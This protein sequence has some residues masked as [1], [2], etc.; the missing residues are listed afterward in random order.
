M[1]SRYLAYL[2]LAL[3]LTLGAYFRLNDLGNG[4]F[5]ADECI[6]AMHAE[7]D[8]LSD[9]IDRVSQDV[10]PPGLH[11]MTRPI[12]KTWGRSQ[13]ALRFPSAVFGI[14]AILF[15]YILARTQ[16]GRGFSLLAALLLSVCPIAIEESRQL[17]PYSLLC[18]FGALTTL[19]V[20]RLAL[21]PSIPRLLVAIFLC[22]ATLYT[23]YVG[24]I[25]LIALFASSIWVFRHTP[26]TR[27][28]L[29]LSSL[30]TALLFAPWG[31]VL[32]GQLGFR[33]THLW[34]FGLSSLKSMMLENGPF[35]S[36]A[37]PDSTAVA[38]TVL[39][40]TLI[41]GILV[42]IAGR[43]RG[44]AQSGA[45]LAHCFLAFVV[46]SYALGF[47][48]HFFQPKSGLLIYP[49]LLVLCA[50][51]LQHIYRMLRR[52]RV[53]QIVAASVVAPLV[54][55]TAINALEYTP[56]I[57]DRS[58]DMALYFR[59][60]VRDEP[61]ILDCDPGY[62]ASFE[63]YLPLAFPDYPSDRIFLITNEAEL[64][65]NFEK[66]IKFDRF[67]IVHVAFTHRTALPLAAKHLELVRGFCHGMLCATLYEWPDS[68]DRNAEE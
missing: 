59:D 38:G 18:L 40:V 5:W 12:I 8:S 45:C 66:I 42:S 1:R 65:E 44:E 34:P 11:L 58:R 63:F 19:S 49:I 54:V 33:P 23:H 55:A 9:L 64:R 25:L 17:R 4:S 47:W 43:N 31:P 15:T 48:R 16:L 26:K 52:R 30:G 35:S 39:F 62:R 13:Y 10:H 67:W 60:N 7:A 46:V 32:I 3:V 2:A 36:L 51:G 61:V 28:A 37:S 57:I 68:A 22:A 14:A 41:V 21:K 50:A 27:N 6:V 24:A 56:R 29:L 53:N 20:I